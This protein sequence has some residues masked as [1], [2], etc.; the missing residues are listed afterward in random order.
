M[1][2][3]TCKQKAQLM[4]KQG[5]KIK[6]GKYNL[7]VK[8]L[9]NKANYNSYKLVFFWKIFNKQSNPSQSNWKL[10]GRMGNDIKKLNDKGEKAIKR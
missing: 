9:K 7:N 5:R 4:K 8:N 3:K 10:Q 6:S 1:R 2:E